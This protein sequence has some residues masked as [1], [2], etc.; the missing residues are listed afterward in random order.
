MSRQAGNLDD[1]VAGLKAKMPIPRER[2]PREKVEPVRE[3]TPFELCHFWQSKY[4]QKF[5]GVRKEGAPPSGKHLKLMQQLKNEFPQEKVL[6]M[7]GWFIHNCQTLPKYQGAPTIEGLWGW[8]ETCVLAMDGKLKIEG[9]KDSAHK[10]DSS[11]S[12]GVTRL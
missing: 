9:R 1:I 5:P 4:N 10:R 6:K 11:K 12:E 2:K 3:K 7:I 8:R